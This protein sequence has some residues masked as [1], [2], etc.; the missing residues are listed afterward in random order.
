MRRIGIAIVCLMILLPVAGQDYYK[1]RKHSRI[2]TGL[3]E[4]AAVPYAD[5]GYVYITQSTSVGPSSPQNPNGEKLFTIF[6]MEEGGQ[7]KP[8]SE[9][10]VTPGHDGP[11]SF[12][13]DFNTMVF[14]QMRSSAANRDFDPLGLYFAE[15]VDGTWTNIRE[16][17]HNDDFAWLFSPALSPD[18]R[19]LFFAANFPD[20]LG[21]YD[22]YRS[23]KRGDSWSEPENLGPAINTSGN[24]LY[25][26]YHKTG[27]L[28]FSSNNR[29]GNTSDY[30]IYETKLIQGEW[31]EAVKLG[32]KINSLSNDYHISFSDDFKEGMLTSDKG[33]GSKEIFQLSTEVPAMESPA[34][35]KKTYYKYMI[36][37]NK[38]DSINTDLFRY[39]WSINDTLELPGHEVIFRF[40]GPGRYVCRLN[41]Y[42]IQLDT[43]VDGRTEKVL[44]INLNEQA[45]I[46]CPDTIPVNTPVEFD[47]SATHLPGF[48]IGEYYWE[49]GDGTYG[50]GLRTTHTYLY[51]GKYRVVLGVEKRKQRRRDPSE[52][53]SNFKDVTVVAQ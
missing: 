53:K 26:F 41:V 10:L 20:G 49:F 21:G 40:P 9:G 52:L 42:D 2:S 37:D 28:Y 31:I 14:A 3:D 29:D 15:R 35:I 27:K 46:T 34:P 18:G 48:D 19:Y 39:S 16:Y 43:L 13:E 32:P 1:V 30:D 33:S 8:L 51:P 25:P 24:E 23:V 50:D 6:L 38:L 7:K 45:V 36:Q 4:A 17:E 5:G 47:A 11:A 22:I 44:N 12:T